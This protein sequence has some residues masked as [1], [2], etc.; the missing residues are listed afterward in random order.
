MKQEVLVKVVEA[1]VSSTNQSTECKAT[2]HSDLDN[3]PTNYY[4]NRAA[5]EF[6][7]GCQSPESR[8]TAVK[9]IVTELKRIDPTA[10]PA[11]LGFWSGLPYCK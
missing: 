1:V 11:D 10:Y 9:L 5:I 7:K 8:D 3:I 6:S 2:S 4:L